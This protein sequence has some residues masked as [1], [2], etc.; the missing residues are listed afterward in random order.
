MPLNQ[1]QQQQMLIDELVLFEDEGT[2]ATKVNSLMPS[3]WQFYDNKKVK[4]QYWYVR[5]SLLM[6]LQAQARYFVDTQNGP[7]RVSNNQFFKNATVM[8]EYADK[9]IAILDPTRGIA[10]LSQANVRGTLP[11][12]LQEELAYFNRQHMSL[13]EGSNS[14]DFFPL[15]GEEIL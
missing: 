7:D 9:Q 11:D 13:A 2:V 10:K 14:T 3:W 8:L 1:Q 15:Y 4:L 5:R 6:F 12:S